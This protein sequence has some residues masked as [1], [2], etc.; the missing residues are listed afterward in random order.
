MKS[1]EKFKVT[2]QLVII[3]IL[4]SSSPNQLFDNFGSFHSITIPISTLISMKVTGCVLNLPLLSCF[5]F[6]VLLY[7]WGLYSRWFTFSN[8]KIHC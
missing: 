1:L 2:F 6:T 5:F 3:S 4:S 7:M 8:M